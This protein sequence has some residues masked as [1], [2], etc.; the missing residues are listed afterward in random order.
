MSTALDIALNM[1]GIVFLGCLEL[2][3]IAASFLLISII[4]REIKRIWKKIK[5]KDW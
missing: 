2:I 4:T 3:I 5:Y 1:L